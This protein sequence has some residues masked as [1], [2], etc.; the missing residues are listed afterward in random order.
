MKCPYC[1]EEIQDEAVLCRFCGAIKGGDGWGPPLPKAEAF[2]KRKGHFTIRSAGVLFV[3]S[4]VY[5]LFSITSEVPL[6]GALRGGATAMIYHLIFIVGFLAIGIG[7]L[8]G[9][10]WGYFLVFG[11]TVFCT[12]DRALYMLDGKARDA[13]VMK[14]LSAY[15]EFLNLID[16]NSLD[17][18]MV[19]V[20]MTSTACW[21]GFALYI[22]L[23]REYFQPEKKAFQSFRPTLR[24]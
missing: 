6:F 5:E 8:T 12:I 23:R 7:L 19:I 22:Y 20:A 4:A 15:K 14:Q 1:A 3:L 18:L 11:E 9:K 24:E 2:S 21:W 13:Y 10:R 16:R 17:Q